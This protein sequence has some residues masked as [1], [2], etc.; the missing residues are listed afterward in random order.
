MAAILASCASEPLT[1]CGAGCADWADECG[2]GDPEETICPDLCEMRDDACEPCFRCIRANPA[3][4]ACDSLA[5]ACV[6]ECNGC[7]FLSSF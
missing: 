3:D 5:G 4:A 6:S 7:T 2:W 1:A